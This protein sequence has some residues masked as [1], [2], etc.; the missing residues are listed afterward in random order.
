MP[1]WTTPALDCV[2]QAIRNTAG[3]VDVTYK[4]SHTGEGLF[5]PTPWIYTYGFAGKPGS[6]IIGFLQLEKDYQGHFTYRN[7]LL[8]LNTKP[9]QAQIDATRPVMRAI[10]LALAEHCGLTELPA[11]VREDCI[12]VD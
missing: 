5:E 12:G 3:V 6:N 2:Q 8:G 11:R 10:E 4:A 9:P 1:S 7:T